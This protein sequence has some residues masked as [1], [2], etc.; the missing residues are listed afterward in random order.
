MNRTQWRLGFRRELM[1]ETTR[2][3]QKRQNIM[4]VSMRLAF[5][6]RTGTRSTASH[7]GAA[8]QHHGVVV[9]IRI[10]R[11]SG[12]AGLRRFGGEII[13]ILLILKSGKS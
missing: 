5:M 4:V 7:T 3:I 12:L 11:I 2:D 1:I 9:R 10:I 8:V 13:P 6:E